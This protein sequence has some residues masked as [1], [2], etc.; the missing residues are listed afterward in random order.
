MKSETKMCLLKTNLCYG[1]RKVT[2]QFQVGAR[3]VRFFLHIGK[4]KKLAKKAG[5][6]IE[7]SVCAYILLYR[8]LLKNSTL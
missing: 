7:M 3:K 5:H 6:P 2:K 8:Q 4:K 1:L